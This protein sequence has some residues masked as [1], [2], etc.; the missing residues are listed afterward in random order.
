MRWTNFN[1]IKAMVSFG[2]LLLVIFE[3]KNHTLLLVAQSNSLHHRYFLLIKNMSAK[4]G[5]LIAIQNHPLADIQNVILT[6][7]LIGVAGDRISL[8]GRIM[9]VN[10]EWQGALH[11]HNSQGHLLTP[12]SIKTIPE[13]FVFVAGSHSGSLDSRYAEFGLVSRHHIL[14]RVYGLW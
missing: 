3:V 10:Q 7:R 6:K 1:M 14:G 8:Q 5:D 4:K 9:R 2:L 12:L 11:Q 13:G